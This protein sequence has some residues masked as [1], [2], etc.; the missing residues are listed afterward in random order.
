MAMCTHLANVITG[1]MR[2]Q[3]PVP[4]QGACLYHTAC[5]LLATSSPAAAGFTLTNLD[6]PNTLDGHSRQLRDDIVDLVELRMC[7]EVL[8]PTLSCH[9]SK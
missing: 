4:A 3:R 6:D 5:V 7:P 9:I 1:G 8:T 2:V